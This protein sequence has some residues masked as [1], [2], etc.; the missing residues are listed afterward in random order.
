[1]GYSP[2]VFAFVGWSMLCLFWKEQTIADRQNVAGSV[3]YPMV[4]L[5]LGTALDNV[6]L[7]AGA[8]SGKA[9]ASLLLARISF[10]LHMTALPMLTATFTSLLV[11]MGMWWWLGNILHILSVPFVV[12]G[13]NKYLAEVHDNLEYS[14]DGGVSR[15]TTSIP[16]YAPV[17]TMISVGSTL[18]AIV[19]V[20]CYG[21]FVPILLQVISLGLQS[22]LPSFRAEY[23]L[24]LAN[25]MEVVFLA[26]I[27]RIQRS[28]V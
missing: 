1:M 14:E 13:L 24:P 19:T 10:F 16:D 8:I 7:C 9:G 18:V 20:F 21:D 11:S 5:T 25:I 26:G 4:L 2:L 15:Y 12:N 23:R 6:R 28:I 22:S 17:I 27:M 3:Y